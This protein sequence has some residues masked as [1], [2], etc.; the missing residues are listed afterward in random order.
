MYVIAPAKEGLNTS[1]SRI[2]EMLARTQEARSTRKIAGNSAT[3]G[4]EAN[5][6]PVADEA[7]QAYGQTMNLLGAHQNERS[8]HTGHALDPERVA[9]LLEL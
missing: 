3:T 6:V 2:E 1:L 8:Q 5:A 4:L 7:D 9:R